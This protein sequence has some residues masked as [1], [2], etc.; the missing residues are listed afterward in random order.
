VDALLVFVFASTAFILSSLFF[1]VQIKMMRKWD[2]FDHPTD[3]KIHQSVTPS[4]GG[5]CILL[6]VIFTLAMALPLA[7]WAELKYFFVAL[8]IIFATG[9]RDD[10]LTLKP[11]Q[12]LVGQLLPMFVVVVFGNLLLDSFYEFN[13]EPLP[14]PISWVITLFTLVAL[15]NAFNLIDGIDGLAG[16]I[17]AVVLAALGA[18]FYA[19]GK[20]FLAVIAFSFVGAIGGFLI[21][22]WQPSKI[23]MG[24]TGTLPI[25]F[26]LSF[27]LIAF[28]NS[29]YR[30]EPIHAW[31]FQAS[32]ST[33][34]ALFVVPI[35]DTLRVIALR[36]RRGQSPFQAD[37]SHL[38][39]DL[40]RLG[41]SH[42]GATLALVAFNISF[43]LLAFVFRNQP[44]AV[45]LPVI[46]AVCT[47]AHFALVAG[48][49]R[50]KS[51]ATGNH[52]DKVGN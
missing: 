23:F 11:T 27:L 10:V 42:Q 48:L 16:S 8:G 32:I 38:H 29:N 52:N 33:A 18:W 2:L 13:A 36:I 21:Y 19:S 30:L 28:I 44:D 25:G 31:K 14:R 6:G 24:D 49:R 39:H 43:V 9:L 4:M 1:P 20:P 22:N 45:L 12:K 50:Q 37:R 5:V 15:T 34:V 47:L 41:L 40:L 26:A 46:V 17:S 7:Q 3:H 51:H 35:F